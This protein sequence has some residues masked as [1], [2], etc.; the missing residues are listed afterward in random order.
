MTNMFKQFYYRIKII[1]SDKALL[2]WTL[3]FPMT[4][5]LFFNLTLR[6]AFEIKPLSVMPIA[7]VNVE[8][9][10]TNNF[11]ESLENVYSLIE[12][13][14]FKSKNQAIQDLELGKIDAIVEYDTQIR[15]TV[16]SES[17]VNATVVANVFTSYNQKQAIIKEQLSLD[18]SKVTPEFI[19]SLVNTNDF[20]NAKEDEKLNDVAMI[21]M[22][23]T[24]AML[25][26][27]ASQWGM[28]SGFYMQA[29][30]S[31]LAIRTNTSPTKKQSIV[32]MDLCVVYVIFIVELVIH[33]L[34]LRFALNVSMGTQPLILISTGLMGGL[35]SAAM[36]Y[37]FSVSFTSSESSRAYLISGI[38][39][40]LN[41]FSGMMS[42]DVKYFIDSN[43]PLINKLNPA[44]LITDNLYHS[45][46]G[47]NLSESLQN[48][49]IMAVL[50]VLFGV[51]AFR[52]LR[53][54]TYDS[55]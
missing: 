15:L 26:I 24:I 50:T 16:P 44:A 4:L 47:I 11:L 23:T 45:Y 38:G 32:L 14:S 30:K 9:N 12:V 33:L 53:T 2:Y 48:I 5:A 40:L 29:D 19:E 13:H 43:L 42:V 25:C 3:L 8:D 49:G 36:G 17:S 39:V 31:K 27:Y 46:L 52:K 54:V 7:V 6:N 55:I 35:L 41:F 20:I 10:A 28:R 51:I 1:I 21:N 18:A 37:M 22:Y 34:F